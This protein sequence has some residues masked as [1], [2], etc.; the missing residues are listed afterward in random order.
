MNHKTDSSYDTQAILG[1][2]D[3]YRDDIVGLLQD[4]IRI[5]TVNPP[6]EAYED[7]VNFMGRVLEDLGYETDVLR[8]PED[9][10]EELA[11]HGKGLPRPNLVA[12]LEGG[13]GGGSRV[14]L[15]GH[16]D[17]VPVG[18]DWTRDP[19]GG[20]LADGRSYGRGA[21]DMK[22]GLVSQVFAVEALRRAGVPWQGSVIQ[23]AVPDEETVGVT[24][25]GTYYL[26]EQGRIRPDNTDAV[27][28]TEPFGSEGVGIG[29]KGAIWGEITIYGQQAHGS[30]PL[31]GVNAV[32][33]AAEYLTAIDAELRPKL[34]ERLC[35]Y[36]VTPSESVHST[37]S[38]DTIEGGVATNIV[39]DRCTLSF[40]RRLLPGEELETAREELLGPLE[41][42]SD[43]QSRFSY[44]YNE[45]YA[46]PP[47]LVSAEEPLVKTAQR[48]VRSLG[49]TPKL[50]ISAGSDDQ[51][52]VVHNAGITNSI[53][54]GPGRTGE[55][56]TA[57]ESIDIE[58]LITTVKGLA[59]ILAETLRS[60]AVVEGAQG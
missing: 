42:V 36:A 9:R 45:T 56:H 29:H 7:F 10:L 48:T 28:I 12:R 14:H 3:E 18:N 53:I 37:L 34:S 25:A 60:D 22:S 13:A 11:P 23:S 15:N 27:I 50:L 2:V 4:F 8:V 24:N 52:F 35:E 38:F 1:A 57:D 16:Y 46:T 33:M 49:L 39:P 55:S 19:F 40:N 26:V 6:G 54:Y 58:E 5:P 17:V 32:E 51:R 21:T 20:E 47:T 31:L 59:L 41:R 44:H 43:G 30:S